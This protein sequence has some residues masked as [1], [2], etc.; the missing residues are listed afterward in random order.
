MGQLADISLPVPP[1][2]DQRDFS[3]IV[4]RVEMIQTKCRESL[5]KAE[6][7]F[8]TLLHRAFTNGL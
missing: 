8:Q 7:L 2:S 4:R 3:R 6:H 1:L 5:R